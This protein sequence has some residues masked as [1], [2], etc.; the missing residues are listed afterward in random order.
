ML[1]DLL[2]WHVKCVMLYEEASIGIDHL[3]DP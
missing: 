3:K 2:N 1:L